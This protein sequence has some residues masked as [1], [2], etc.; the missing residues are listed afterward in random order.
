NVTNLLG[1]E[2]ISSVGT[3]GFAASDAGESNQTFM[4]GAPQQVYFTLRKK[5]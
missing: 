5:F 4:V 2:Y 3:N 1:E